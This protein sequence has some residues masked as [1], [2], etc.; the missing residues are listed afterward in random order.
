MHYIG[1]LDKNK[2]GIYAEKIITDDVILTDE[3][4]FHIFND[5]NKD[6]EIIINNIDRVILNPKMVLED[7]KNR[8][9]LFFINKLDYHNLN[10]ILKLNTTNS[11]EHPQNSVMTAWIIRNSNL[12]KLIEKNK[13]VYKSE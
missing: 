12:K 13:I 7:S 8:N 6:Y 10:V 9:T 2:I 4:K 3:R 5:H 11:E 1:K